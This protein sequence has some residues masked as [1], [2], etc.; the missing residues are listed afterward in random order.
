MELTFLKELMLTIQANQKSLIFVAIDIF[1]V[2]SLIF[3][4]MPAVVVVM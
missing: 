1:Q 2:K 3:N 4:H